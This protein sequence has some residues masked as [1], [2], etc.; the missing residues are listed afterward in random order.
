MSEKS[1]NRYPEGVLQTISKI[2]GENRSGSEI[3]EI[4][5]NA[6]YPEHS[7]VIGT[8]WRFLYEL[9]KNF[10]DQP[11]GQLHIAKIIQI[12]CTPTKW[13]GREPD[14]VRSINEINEALLFVN[15]QVNVAGKV[16]ITDEKRHFAEPQKPET[17]NSPQYISIN[18][19]FRTRNIEPELQLCF[20]L[21]P[22]RPSFE[23]LYNEK[24]KPT[25][26]H[27]GF[28]CV[29]ANDLYSPTPII[30]DIWI[31]IYK[32]QVIIADVTDR[33]PNVFY[34]I[35][36]AHTIGKPVIIITQNKDDVPFDVSQYRYF[37][38]TDDINGWNNLCDNLRAA[39]IPFIDRKHN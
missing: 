3:S 5:K 19:I 34:E 15:L 18:P 12:F 13:I 26:N 8:K 29:K 16:I 27:C 17:V 31:H 14:R 24:I 28:K 20:V 23:R 7:I 33:N 9:F 1:A 6:G 36:I 25:V 39:L 10:N 37:Q 30:E 4:L 2:I 32:S 21:M 22:F 38:Y 11:N 35:G